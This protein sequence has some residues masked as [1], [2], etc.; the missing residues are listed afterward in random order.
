MIGNI[1][2]AKIALDALKDLGTRISLDDF[3]TGFSSLATLSRLPFDKIKIDKSFV[4]GVQA[5]PQNGKIVTA[6][7]ALAQSMD[8]TVTAEG[9]E[10]DAELNFLTEI[11]CRQGQSFLFAKALGARG[12]ADFLALA[13]STGSIQGTRKTS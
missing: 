3:G 4:S 7:L 6:I 8:L 5:V 1:D 2:E 9:I 10:T 12:V 11:H 13:D